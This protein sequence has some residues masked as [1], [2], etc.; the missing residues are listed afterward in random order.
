MDIGHGRIETRN[1]T[2]VRRWWATRW[3]GLAQVF[4]IGRHVITQ[5][6]AKERVEVVYGVTS[7]R[8][9]R[10]TPTGCLELVRVIGD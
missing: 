6:T 1:L 9:E 10:A 2:T 8:P 5:K 3:P 7:L 4:E